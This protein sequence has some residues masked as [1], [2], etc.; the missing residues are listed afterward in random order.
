MLAYIP[1][2]LHVKNEAYYH[3][4]MLLWLRLLGF[5]LAGEVMTDTGRIDAV[6]Q[7]PG[8]VIIAEVKFHPEEGKLPRLLD[9]A[10][11][12]INERRYADRFR[13]IQEVSLLAVALSG[14]EI[15]C[16]VENL[17]GSR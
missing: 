6:W 4:L 14:K 17:P 15:G 3:S 8:R 16:R 13:E 2:P 7:L 9:E 10:L 1:Y 5:D 12:Q 11:H